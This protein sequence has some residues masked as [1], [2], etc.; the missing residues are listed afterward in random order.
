MS[1][2]QTS[3]LIALTFEGQHTAEALYEQVEQMEK[4]KLV[5]IE[6]AVIIERAEAVGQPEAGSRME[7]ML[8][9]VVKPV[10]DGAIEVKQTRGKKGKYAAVGGGIGLLAAAILGGPIGLVA[11]AGA[12]VGALTGALKDF[13]INDASVSA[14]TQNLQPNT[15]AL[16]L[17]GQAKD[18]DALLA[19]LRAFDAK[20]VM[21]TLDPEA[22]RRLAA[23]LSEPRP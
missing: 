6:D 3:T 5:V 2:T 21:T 17:L 11:V 8:T 14:I 19:K 10:K 23:R 16:L 13:G 15:S 20:V 7:Q 22:E 9:P 4:D 12:G 18:P 1:E